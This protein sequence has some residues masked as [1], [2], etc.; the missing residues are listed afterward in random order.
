MKKSAEE[1]PVK[2]NVLCHLQNILQV[3]ELFLFLGSLIVF[4]IE[5]LF[6]ITLVMILTGNKL[7]LGQ[8]HFAYDGT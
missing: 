3:T 8:A 7:I 6:L 2:D 5:I 4:K 1:G